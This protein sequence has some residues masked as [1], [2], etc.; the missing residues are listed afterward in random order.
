MT[1]SLTKHRD[2]DDYFNQAQSC[3]QFDNQAQSWW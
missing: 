1:I 3:W 2:D